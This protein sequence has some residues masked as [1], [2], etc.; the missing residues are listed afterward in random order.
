M[1]KK[2]RRGDRIL[3]ASRAAREA[4]LSDRRK[5]PQLYAEQNGTV[6]FVENVAAL[7]GCSLDYVRR[8]P[9]QQLPAARCG[10]RLQYLRE[11][12]EAYVRRNR[13]RGEGQR[14]GR[15]ETGARAAV[16][17][18]TDATDLVTKTREKLRKI[19]K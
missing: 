6:L 8:I 1:T 16:S 3:A 7:L 17:L 5:S 19:G 11:D 12:V 9:R 4:A 13:N 2:V 10:P 18:D 14:V 15:E